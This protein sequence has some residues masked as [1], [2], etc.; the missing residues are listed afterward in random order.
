MMSRRHQETTVITA[1]CL[2][3]PV[4]P[5]SLELLLGPLALL[6]PQLHGK[7]FGGFEST[8]LKS[9]A[10]RRVPGPGAPLGKAPHQAARSVPWAPPCADHWPRKQLRRP[11]CLISAFQYL[12]KSTK[13]GRAQIQHLFQTVNPKGPM[14]VRSRGHSCQRPGPETTGGPGAGALLGK[15]HL[16]RCSQTPPPGVHPRPLACLSR[17]W[18]ASNKDWTN[19][20]KRPPH[21]DLGSP[22]HTRPGCFPHRFLD[23]FSPVL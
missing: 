18:D 22:W 8:A 15:H 10:S 20:P 7:A 12:T 4:S 1:T 13:E 21:L 2:T 17:A 11:D 23:I 6:V 9:P 16:V 3:A 14:K 5:A 19:T